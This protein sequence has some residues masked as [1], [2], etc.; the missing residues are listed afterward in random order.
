MDNET[1]KKK[2]FALREEKSLSWADLATKAGYKSYRNILNALNSP[3]LTLST[4]DKIAHALDIQVFELLKPDQDTD[5]QPAPSLPVVR[6]PICGG[7]LTVRIE[8]D[9]RHQET[10]AP[11]VLPVIDSRQEKNHDAGNAQDL[12]IFQ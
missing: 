1:I 11:A 2:L 7:R 6:C 5:R 9:D 12:T 10:P 4:L 3:G 8:P